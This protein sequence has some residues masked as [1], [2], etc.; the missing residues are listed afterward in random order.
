[1]TNIDTLPTDGA[2][3]EQIN[4]FLS[5][6]DATASRTKPNSRGFITL[7]PGMTVPFGNGY[8]I[9]TVD[10][11]ADVVKDYMLHMKYGAQLLEKK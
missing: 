10:G 5:T 4:M 2:T 3:E 11:K 6:T 1:M 7:T 8:F 9:V